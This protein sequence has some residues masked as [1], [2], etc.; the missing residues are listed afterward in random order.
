MG[1]KLV[2]LGRTD[3]ELVLDKKDRL[4]DRHRAVTERVAD[5]KQ[6]LAFALQ[7]HSFNRDYDELRQR[8][9]AKI[10]L[11]NRYSNTLFEALHSF[12]LAWNLAAWSCCQLFLSIC[13][14]FI[15][16]NY[17]KKII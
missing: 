4:L 10:L 16:I 2:R 13:Y 1:D 5:Y 12:Y 6:R 17:F 9:A 3:R 14:W 15:N 7:V 8:L 11:L